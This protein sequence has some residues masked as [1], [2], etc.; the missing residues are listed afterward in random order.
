MKLSH[1]SLRGKPQRSEE[2]IGGGRLG[3]PPDPFLNLGQP[4]RG[5]MDIVPLGDVG[6]GLEQLLEAIVAVRRLVKYRVAGA[7]ARRVHHRQH[8]CLASHLHVF[9]CHIPAGT[10]T[11]LVAG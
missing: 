10:P 8:P 1:F 6:K 2:R 11:R 9:L 7:A 5:P 3:L 4:L